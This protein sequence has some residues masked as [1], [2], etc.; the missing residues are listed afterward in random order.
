MDTVVQPLLQAIVVAE[1]LHAVV[2]VLYS[3]IVAA[4]DFSTCNQI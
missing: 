1:R 2:A 3:S 4:L